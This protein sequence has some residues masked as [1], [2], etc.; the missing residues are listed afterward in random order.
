[1]IPENSK[2]KA[3]NS[4][5][6]TQNPKLKIQ[7][8]KYKVQNTKFKLYNLFG[9]LTRAINQVLLIFIYF[10]LLFLIR[11]T[12]IAIKI[13]SRKNRVEKFQSPVGLPRLT[14]IV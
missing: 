9:I 7:N 12:A 11:K 2:S 4:K 8:S 14:K 1:M 5:H 3:Q 10:L 13:R 6:K